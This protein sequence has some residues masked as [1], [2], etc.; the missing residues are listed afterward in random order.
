MLHASTSDKARRASKDDRYPRSVGF[1]D[2]PAFR[3][4][5]TGGPLT[6]FSGRNIVIY[7][8]LLVTRT[9]SGERVAIGN[10]KELSHPLSLI[11]W[12]DLRKA[13]KELI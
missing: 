9:A 5:H 8:K 11:D 2:T 13:I 6:D 3:L 12:Y 4:G 1:H 10:K 7:R